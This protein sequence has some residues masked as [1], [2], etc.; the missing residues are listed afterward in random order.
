M[1]VAITSLAG[2][3]WP[4]AKRAVP[5]RAPWR[6]SICSADHDVS[7]TGPVWEPLVA[8]A[9]EK[10]T[11]PKSASGSVWQLSPEQLEGA[12]RIQSAELMSIREARRV[13]E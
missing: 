11:P 3:T 10:E 8:V 2:S 5:G 13:I 4:L 7:C 6:S 9:A 1:E 12:S